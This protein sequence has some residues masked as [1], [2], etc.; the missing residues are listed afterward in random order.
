[1]QLAIVKFMSFDFCSQKQASTSRLLNIFPVFWRN[2]KMKWPWI[3]LT[4]GQKRTKSRLVL[5]TC[6]NLNS[7]YLFFCESLRRL[8]GKQAESF[9][10]SSLFATEV[11]HWSGAQTTFWESFRN[12]RK[13]CRGSKVTLFSGRVNVLWVELILL[14]I[15]A[16]VKNE[17]ASAGQRTNTAVTFWGFLWYRLLTGLVENK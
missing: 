10:Y 12:D 5:H 7:I 1:M 16:D 13:N 6:R 8:Y 4:F 3:T 17:P 15:A 14:L 2:T 9:V 11:E